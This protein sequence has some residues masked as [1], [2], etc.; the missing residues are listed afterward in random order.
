MTLRKTKK[1]KFFLE[2]T[3]AGAHQCIFTEEPNASN[4]N[5]PPGNENVNFSISIFSTSI[6]F[7]IHCNPKHTNSYNSDYYCIFPMYFILITNYVHIFCLSSSLKGSKSMSLQENLPLKI[8]TTLLLIGNQHNRG[9]V[10]I[11]T[12]IKGTVEK[13]TVETTKR[14]E[15]FLYSLTKLEIQKSCDQIQHRGNAV[16]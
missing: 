7:I 13:V 5:A 16:Q 14:I 3:F 1:K 11:H 9:S 12:K 4:T 10:I 8:S 15:R 2:E 6:I